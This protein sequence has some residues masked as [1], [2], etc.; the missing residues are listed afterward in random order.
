MPA[1]TPEAAVAG[2]ETGLPV[3]G[4]ANRYIPAAAEAPL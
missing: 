4:E 2:I 3:F 1:S